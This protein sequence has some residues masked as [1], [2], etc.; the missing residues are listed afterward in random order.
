MPLNVAKNKGGV[1][2]SVDDQE[3]PELPKEFPGGNVIRAGMQAVGGAIPFLGGLLGAF[4]GAW[5]EH[6]QEKVKRVFEQWL[7]MLEDELREKAKTIAEIAARVDLGD[8][9][10]RERIE[11]PEYQ[12]LM[13][14]AFRN[15]QNID[16]E[17]KRQKIRNILSN[18]AA[19]KLS[20][21][22]VIRL[23]LDWIDRYSDF[24]FAVI[25]EIYNYGPIGR[26]DIWDNLGKEPV[27]EDSA[28]ADLFRLLI[29]DLSVGRVIRQERPTDGAGNFIK[30]QRAGVGRSKVVVSQTMK[31]AFDNNDH[32]VLSDLGRQFVHYA[33]NELVPR[34]T[35]ATEENEFTRPEP[36]LSSR[37]P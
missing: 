28:E 13:K 11:S 31:S 18:A 12:A 34:V 2:M 10:I 15:W 32:Y 14:K 29:H 6:E 30:K 4:A 33:M 19:T 3:R 24:H 26:A 8:E 22:D 7:R 27:R 25:S 37:D 23:F 16:S 17:G 35:F 5:S 1:T 9:R 36:P 20:D 21:D